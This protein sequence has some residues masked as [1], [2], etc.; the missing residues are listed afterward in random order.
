M[1]FERYLP[2]LEADAARLA[3]VAEEGLDAPGPARPGWPIG[4]VVRHLVQVSACARWCASGGSL[5]PTSGRLTCPAG[6]RGP[7]RRSVTGDRACWVLLD[8]DKVSVEPPADGAPGAAG[9]RSPPGS[10]ADERVQD[11]RRHT[12]G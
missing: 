12:V 5:L 8:R 4:A 9:P 2:F 3:A 6:S 1:D 7:L 10:G 11:T